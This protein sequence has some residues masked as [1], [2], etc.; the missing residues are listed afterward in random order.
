[1]EVDLKI[2]RTYQDQI[3]ADSVASVETVGLLGDSYVNITRGTPEQEMIADNGPVKTAEKADIAAVMQNTNQ[4]ILNL[5]P[6]PPSSMKS[7]R[8]SRPA[9]APS[10]N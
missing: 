7:P 2:A 6:F 5:N 3:R 1:M 9:K 4:V 8:K 10:A